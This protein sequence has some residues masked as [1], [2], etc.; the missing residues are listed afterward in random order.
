MIYSTMTVVDMITVESIGVLVLRAG[1]RDVESQ[2]F[3]AATE[4]L[5]VSDGHAHSRLLENVCHDTR[6]GARHV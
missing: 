5:S 2:T 3:I 1:G 6:V 4:P